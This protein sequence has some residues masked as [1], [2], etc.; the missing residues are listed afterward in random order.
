MLKNLQNSPNR[1]SLEILFL[2]I[3][4][5]SLNLILQSGERMLADCNTYLKL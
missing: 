2:C 3:F 5:F 1:N 4:I